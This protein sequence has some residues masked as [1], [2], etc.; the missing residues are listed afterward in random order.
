[1][2]QIFFL[3]CNKV[4][5]LT[6]LSLIFVGFLSPCF[7]QGHPA[8]DD[9]FVGPFPSWIN[10]KTD[11]NVK[12]DGIA[13]ET[14]AL[15]AAFDA[16]GNANSTKSV[17]Y[18]PPGTYRITGTL[19]ITNKMNISI[20]GADPATTKIL[21]NGPNG[22]TMIQI[23]GT[24][25]SRFNRIT[26]DGNGIASIAVDQ[27]RL[28]ANTGYFDT[29]NEYADD[30][31]KNVGIGIR[32]GHFG[33]GF[34][35]TAIMR[36]KFTRNTI[37]G[38]TLG[39]FNAL[40][41]WVWQSV[42]ENCAIGIT[43]LYDNTIVGGGNFKVYGSI[44]R[45]STI[46]DIVIGHTGEFAFR[47]NT[48]TNSKKFVIAIPKF[49]PCHIT[50]QSNT[51]ID[52]VSDT[53]INIQ[54]HGPIILLDNI[55]RSRP[56]AVG[57]VVF[58]SSYPTSDFFSMGNTF[59]V[60]NAIKSTGRKIIYDKPIVSHGSFGT[61]AEPIL[62]GTQPK[63]N[64]TVFEVPAGA[65]ATA[66][67]A[68]INQAALLSGNRPVVHFPH[69]VYNIQSTLNIPAGSDM[70][71]VGDGHGDVYPTWLFW[72][73]GTV[74]PV[75]NIAGPSKVTLRDIS[76]SGE[77]RV[78]GILMTNVDQTGS[79]IFMHE[80]EANLN[81]NGINVNGLDNT[82]VLAHN[83]RISQ[84]AGKAIN[85][86]GGPFA[87]SGNP[88]Q[89]KTIMVGGLIWEN[90]LSYGVTNGGNLLARDVWYE[91]LNNG[92][93]LNISGLGTVTI[94][95]SS[96]ASPRGTAIPQISITNLAG[97]ASLI[98]SYFEDRVTISG[99]GVQTK[100]L[101]LGTLF[102]NNS[103]PETSNTNY[104]E[105]TTSPAGDIRSFISR[106]FKNPN[107]TNPKYGS[108]AVNNIGTIDSAFIAT[109]LEQL[110][111][112]HSQVLTPNSDGITDIRLYRVWLQKTLKGIDIQGIIP[113]HFRTR[114][115]GNWN[116]INTWESSAD[117][118]IWSAATIAPDYHVNTI[119]VLND[120]V[121]T[122]TAN[123]TIDETI[124]NPKGAI[125]VTGSS[126]DVTNIFPANGLTLQSNAIGTAR[127]GSSTGNIIG[128]VTVER[129]ISSASARSA[130]RLLTTPLRSTSTN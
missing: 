44:F 11:F 107:L 101:G 27:A 124:V 80:L 24:A 117:N 95:G 28:T 46:S 71:I 43:N 59:S 68:I 32:G 73:G 29:G 108:F 97:K 16:V 96:V 129:F 17:V 105:N 15:Q 114:Q 104:I 52:P 56:A 35:E 102:G 100:V 85:V 9:E 118:A 7:S 1:P 130:W 125:V 21:W 119:T 13:D 106:S 128:N 70:Q 77:T 33:H 40:D 22:G 61:L 87:S 12:G 98:N 36:C 66:I 90:N 123:T 51:I 19:T 103:L 64:R 88:Q 47:D 48:S 42:F 111:N 54:N 75:I 34:A 99:N 49:Y 83:S 91:S 116:D 126:L 74:G 127:I 53:A 62:P 5:S 50:L 6:I 110:R 55:I 94:E 30:E 57:P 8:T 58:H 89:G 82:L 93:Y 92:Q 120:H 121:I 2:F 113:F 112:E 67:Q 60:T 3:F 72:T 37:A 65:N 81:T 23:Y 26:W 109:M 38:I 115:S 41:V 10:V 78:T 69:G 4:T 45:N 84:S 25:Y 31:F 76:I 79:R 86:T 63:L 39:N 18:L 20:I 122:V 14:A